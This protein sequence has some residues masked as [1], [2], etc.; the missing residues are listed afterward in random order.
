MRPVL[1]CVK[2]MHLKQPA[3]WG[4][5][6]HCAAFPEGVPSD[7]LEA[8]HDHRHP[9]PGDHGIRFTPLDSRSVSENR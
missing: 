9:Y 5:G 4:H 3:G 2:C 8:K 6:Y 1:Q 7:I